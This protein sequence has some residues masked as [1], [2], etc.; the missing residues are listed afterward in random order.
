MTIR[1]YSDPLDMEQDAHQAFEYM[2]NF[3]RVS[4]KRLYLIVRDGACFHNDERD[5]AERE[6]ER[7]AKLDI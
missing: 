3:M 7:R 1:T 4:E 6:L 2:Y 5:M